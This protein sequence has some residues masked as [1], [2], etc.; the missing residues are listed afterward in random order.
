MPSVKHCH[1]P[2]KPNHLLVF[3]PP[4]PSPLIAGGMFLCLPGGSGEV[5][6]D[7]EILGFVIYQGFLSAER[8]EGSWIRQSKGQASLWSQ[9]ESSRELRA[10]M[11]PAW[12]PS[13]GPGT[14][15]CSLSPV[16]HYLGVPLGGVLSS[17]A[18]PVRLWGILQRK[19]P[20]AS[21]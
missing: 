6:L 10:R 4:S 12:G 11:R 18:V 16:R 21:W 2:S 19:Q 13:M 14:G 5:V 17:E 3:F 15:F 1:Q 8:G 20:A 7:T 9:L